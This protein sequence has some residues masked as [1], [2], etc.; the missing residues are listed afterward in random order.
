MPGVKE[1]ELKARRR[2]SAALLTS[3]L[4][5]VAGTD[6][7]IS[8]VPNREPKAKRKKLVKQ[9]QRAARKQISKGKQRKKKKDKKNNARNPLV[10][11]R[12]TRNMIPS[13]AT[14]LRATALIQILHLNR[15]RHHRR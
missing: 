9:Q 13:P 11:T 15:Q 6:S 14:I 8:G 1:A 5:S 3:R 4:A 10:I 12:V 7:R 2:R